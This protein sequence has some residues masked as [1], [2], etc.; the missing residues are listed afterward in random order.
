MAASYDMYV[1]YDILCDIEDNLQKIEYDLNSSTDQMI[2]AIQV[3]QEFL[4]GTQFEKVKRTTAS[5]TDVTIRAG[6]NI[7]HAIKYIAKLKNA[8]DEYGKCGYNGEAE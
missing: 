5:C 8:L 4:A 3:S 6:N 2:K 7:R 1:D